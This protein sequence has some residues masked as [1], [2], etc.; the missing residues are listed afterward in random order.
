[1][2]S[3]VFDSFVFFSIF[4][5]ATS[6]ENIYDFYWIDGGDTENSTGTG[7]EGFLFSYLGERSDFL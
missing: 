7:M 1:M 3:T 2:I 5:V 4:L 6:V